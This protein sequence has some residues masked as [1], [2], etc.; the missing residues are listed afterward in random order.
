MLT[1]T[2]DIPRPNYILVDSA[3]K[4]EQLL[5][6]MSETKRVSFDYETSA[7]MNEN[8]LKL[9]KNSQ[10]KIDLIRS[11]I[12]SSSFRVSSGNCFY[13]SVAH[14]NSF[15]FPKE[16]VADVLRAKP[17]HA[18]LS[19]HNLAFEWLITKKELGLD[20]RDLGPVR[21][22]LMA[23]KVLDSNR[24]AGLKEL[25]LSE[26]GIVQQTYDAVT[27]GRRMDQIP[28]SEVLVYG[29]DD[30]E[31]Q[32]QL[33]ELF[34]KRLVD[35]GMMDYYTELE[36]PIVPIMAEITLRGAYVPEEIIEKKTKEHLAKMEEYE[37]K[38][39]P[40]LGRKINLGSPAALSKILYGEF[41]LPEP[42]YAESKTMTDKESMYWNIDQHPVMPLL[43]EWKKYS[44]RY[45]LY[46]KPYPNLVHPD[47][48]RMHAVFKALADTSRFTCSSPNLQ[49]LAKRGDGIEVRE[50]YVP[51]P[52]YDCILACDMSQVELVLAAHRSRSPVLLEAY[53][54]VRGDIHTATCCAIFVIEKEAA[55]ANKVFRTAGKTANFSLL[56]GGMAK[57]IYRLIKLE[58]AKMG[59]GMPFTMRDVE[60][61]IVRFFGLYPELKAMQKAD[62]RF[63]R[64]NGYVKSLFGRRFYLPDIDSK[65]SFYRSKAERKAT[66]SPIQGTCAELIK[67]AIIKIYEERIPVSDARM[68]AS[69]H[70][71][72]VFY[73]TN[74]AVKDVAHIVK[75]HMSNTPKGLLA[76]MASEVE[77]GPT[78]GNLIAEEAYYQKIGV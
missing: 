41:N 52:E 78:F 4:F 66:N 22:T 56:Y 28:A 1:I 13:L 33:D 64:E 54:P 53:G 70:D 40:F 8:Y 75:K 27:K 3:R 38:I 49:Q 6:E 45:K 47:T 7:I 50:M 63:A 10:P 39:W 60:L 72:N 57:R 73:C 37:E 35:I 74:K 26:F 62:V 21:D 59:L 46:D 69:I 29:C 20:L 48:G 17:K 18:P 25:V 76:H 42:P 23:S 15:N 14:A 67:R 36:V 5:K 43:I 61:M 2:T 71:E 12:T 19:A 51:P 11:K 16:A 77:I 58:L 24:Q 55:K 68:W 44:T 30:S 34:E 32:W 9:N 65:N 31:Y